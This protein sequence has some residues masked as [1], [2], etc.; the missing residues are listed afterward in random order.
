MKRRRISCAELAIVALLREHPTKQ[1]SYD[2]LSAR[3]N[4]D[5]VTCINAVA[6]LR[7]RGT[8]TVVETGRGGRANQYA[9][10]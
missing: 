9:L 10:S 3:I 1:I 7:T 4:A 5:R 6:R 8:L 2:E